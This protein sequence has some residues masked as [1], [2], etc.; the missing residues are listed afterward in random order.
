LSRSSDKSPTLGSWWAEVDVEKINSN[1]WL[2]PKFKW[3]RAV[4]AIALLEHIGS[5]DAVALLKEIAGGHPLAQPTRE[6]H[7]ALQRA[8]VK[9]ESR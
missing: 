1:S 4:K 2:N 7:Q 9:T 6:A 3:T 5:A 8:V